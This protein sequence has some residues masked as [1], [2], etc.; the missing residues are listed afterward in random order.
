[1]VDDDSILGRFVSHSGGYPGFGS[2]MRWHPKSGW[3]IV[4]LGNR[5]YAPMV[6][7]AS[8]ALALIVR[9]HV[10]VKVVTESDVWQET[11]A[12][13]AVVEKLIVNW[14]DQVADQSFASNMD[15]DQPRLERA[16][17]IAAIT[18]GNT[19]LTRVVGS[20][21]SNTPAHAKW[22]VS[23]NSGLIELELL[24]SPTRP[25]KIQTL[26]VAKVSE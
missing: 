11:A 13:M 14:S 22:L 7:A 26:K 2:H 4:T 25:A 12:A 17:A 23:G 18:S 20:M 16:A 24:M 5:T 3:A 9:D 1:M 6:F 8:E 21:T 10:S 19:D 15:L